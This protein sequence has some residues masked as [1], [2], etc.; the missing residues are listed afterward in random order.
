MRREQS[1]AYQVEHDQGQCPEAVCH[2]AENR[3]ESRP[4]QLPDG[5]RIVA[6][7]EMGGLHHRYERRAA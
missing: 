7:P 3:S 5:E 2:A 4:A 1:Q 6:I